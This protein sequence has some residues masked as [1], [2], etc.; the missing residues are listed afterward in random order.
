[1]YYL[2]IF[3]A[4]IDAI[5]VNIPHVFSAIVLLGAIASVVYFYTRAR[6]A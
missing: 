6:E 5:E 1:M 3:S 2:N 4:K